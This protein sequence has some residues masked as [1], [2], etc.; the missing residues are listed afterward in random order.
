[1]KK[2]VFLM[3]SI[4]ILVIVSGLLFYQLTITQNLN[5]DLRNQNIEIQNRL[6]EIQNN[7]SKLENQITELQN[8]NSELQNQINILQDQISG[9]TNL[10][11]ITEFKVYGL[12]PIG[13]MAH[14]STANL[15]LFNFGINDVEMI[16]LSIISNNVEVLSKSVQIEILH[17]GEELKISKELLFSLSVDT[18]PFTARLTLNDEILDQSA[19]GW[20]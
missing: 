15:T 7:T 9:F 20:S 11:K 6:Y 4:I 16:T 19:T 14:I 5:S 3:I 1:M 17:A 18:I 12:S 8:Q 2:L 13:G 10:V